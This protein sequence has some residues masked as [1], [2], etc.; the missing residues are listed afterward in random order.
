MPSLTIFCDI[1]GEWDDNRYTA[2]ESA[3]KLD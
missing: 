1:K 2:F 3:G